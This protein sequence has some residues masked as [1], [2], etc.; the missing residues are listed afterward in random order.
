MSAVVASLE[1]FNEATMPALRQKS[2]K[3]TSYLERLLQSLPSGHFSIIT[4]G[5]REERGAQL[6]LRLQP[7]L[8]DAVMR[9]LQANGVI[10]DERRPDVIRVSPAPLYNSFTDV[11]KFCQ[12][13]HEACEKAAGINRAK[14]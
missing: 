3:L 7:G 10:L 11:W 12:I 9:H 2:L 5:N 13:F 1:L 6:S 14:A 8:L 4:P